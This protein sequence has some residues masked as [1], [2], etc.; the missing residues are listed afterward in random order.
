MKTFSDNLTRSFSF[1]RYLLATQ[2][3]I[4]TLLLQGCQ[5]PF[6][7]FPGG[8]LTGEPDTAD[9]F[10]FA[11][12]HA[13]LK[14]EVNPV[15]PYSVILRTTVIKGQLYIDAAKGRKWG[16]ILAEQNKVRLGIGNKVYEAVATPVIN[17]EI[18]K[19]FQQGRIVYRL[20]P[21]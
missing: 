7:V 15:K 12:D 6:L 16:N 8:T 20:D 19:R 9:T 4:C 11:A 5:S 1:S 10:A 21:R 3:L 17:T 14:L 18:V 2:L 13:I